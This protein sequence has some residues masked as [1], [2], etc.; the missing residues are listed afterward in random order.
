MSDYITLH[1]NTIVFQL[2]TCKQ[3][4]IKMNENGMGMFTP[5]P[6]QFKRSFYHPSLSNVHYGRARTALCSFKKSGGI[7]FFE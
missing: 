7:C 3:K 6:I 5:G 1:Y 4:Q 2:I